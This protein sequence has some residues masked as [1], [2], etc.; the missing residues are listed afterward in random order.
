MGMGQNPNTPGEHQH[1]A[2]IYGSSSPF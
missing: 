2:G 1:L